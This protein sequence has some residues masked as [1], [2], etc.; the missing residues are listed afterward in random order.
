M[1][2]TAHPQAK[3]KRT[4][5]AFASIKAGLIEAMAHAKGSAA[6]AGVRVY[7]PRSTDMLVLPGTDLAAD[8]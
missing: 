2:R 7:R 6:G 4:G 5:K 1:K 8:V 3:A